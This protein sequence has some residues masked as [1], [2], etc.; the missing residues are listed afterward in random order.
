M[1]L[2]LDNTGKIVYVGKTGDLGRRLGEHLQGGRQ[3]SVLHEQIGEMLDRP[4]HTASGAEIRDRLRGP[5]RSR[6]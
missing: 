5:A 3:A 6:G 4:G 1:H 2:V